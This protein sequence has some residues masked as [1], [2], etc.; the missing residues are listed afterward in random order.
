MITSFDL[1]MKFLCQNY[2]RVSLPEGITGIGNT[3]D[4]AYR[5]FVSMWNLLRGEEWIPE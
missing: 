1:T 4:A 2:S 3:P 5:D